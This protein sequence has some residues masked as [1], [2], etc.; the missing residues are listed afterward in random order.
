MEITEIN[1]RE[2][3]K[4]IKRLCKKGEIVTPKKLVSEAKLSKLTIYKYIDILEAEGKIK[5]EKIGNTKA[6]RLVE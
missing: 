2:V 4:A 6:I 3:L 5:T 1:K